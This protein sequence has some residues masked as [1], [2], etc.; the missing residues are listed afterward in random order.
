M[1]DDIEKLR[2]IKCVLRDHRRNLDANICIDCTSEWL[3]N[4]QNRN[5]K[6]RERFD[7]FRIT[8]KE[9]S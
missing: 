2:R 7:D 5:E 1:I 9:I 4:Q 8:K 6:L 3:I